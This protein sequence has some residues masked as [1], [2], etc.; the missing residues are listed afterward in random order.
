LDEEELPEARFPHWDL[1]LAFVVALVVVL[2]AVLGTG[3][4]LAW[5]LNPM[6]PSPEAAPAMRSDGG[7]TFARQ[8]DW[9]VFHPTPPPDTTIV[10]GTVYGVKT[11]LIVYPGARVDPR[12]YAPVARALADRGFLV[13]VVPMGLNLAVLSPD[14]ARD[15]MR[16]YPGI[17]SWAVGGHSLGGAMAAR[18]ADAN[19]G[20]VGGLVLWA[21]YPPEGSRLAETTLPCA[22]VFGTADKLATPA[23]IDD[24]KRLL[25][26][27]AAMTPIEGGNHS[28]FGS[29]GAQPGDGKAVISAEEQRRQ[30]VEATVRLLLEVEAKG[31]GCST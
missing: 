10:P 21:A 4:F 14:R 29:Y 30:V 2:G 1:S 9:L 24:A 28:Q 13:V 12:S 27:G 18:F 31:P 25:P 17:T 15:V 5:A 16:A 6:G 3:A 19:K 20:G 26:R 22:S 7:V 11:G 23:E 8:G